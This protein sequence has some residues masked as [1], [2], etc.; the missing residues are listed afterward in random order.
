MDCII[1]N[2]IM[3]G[4]VNRTTGGGKSRETDSQ[5]GASDTVER[6][7]TCVACGFAVTT[8]EPRLQAAVQSVCPNCSDWT[9]QT[10]DQDELLEAADAVAAKLAGPTLTERQ[11]LAYLLRD[12]VGFDRQPTAYSMD[13]S[14]SNVD[15]LQRKAQEKL[16]DANR[17]LAEL[18]AVQPETA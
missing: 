10:A 17:V 18:D 9:T 11:A 8:D 15:N 4:D 16:D 12:I 3:G 2:A 6:S 14:A 1:F 5:I 7:F 13:T